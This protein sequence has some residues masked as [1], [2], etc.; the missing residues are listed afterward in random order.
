M[1]KKSI[2][3][4]EH[5]RPQFMREEF[6]NLN[7]IWS[8]EFDFSESG[9]D[10]ENLSPAGVLAVGWN[11]ASRN[12]AQH[13]IFA[14]EITVPFCPEST[15]SGVGYTD[16]I[17]AIWYARKITIPETWQNKRIILHFGG[18][19]NVTQ[20][21]IDGKF[22]G[23]HKGGQGSFEFDITNMVFPGREHIITV[24]AVDH[25]RE[26][27]SGAG[28]QSF[29]YKSHGCRYTRVTGIWSSVWLEAVGLEGLKRVK[30]IPDFVK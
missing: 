25:I 29:F 9:C 19:D 13:G 26:G 2:P 21:Y 4:P 15:L 14:N 17:P 8:Y 22:A 24:H 23:R 5:P 30:I 20:V 11:G 10:A 3:R 6:L 12:L 1:N 7:G 28:K 16:F 18:V 27:L